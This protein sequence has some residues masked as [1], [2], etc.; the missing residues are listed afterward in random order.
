MIHIRSTL[1]ALLVIG[2]ATVAAAQQPAQQPAQRH[3]K[4]AGQHPGRAARGPGKRVAAGLFRGI[5]LSDA[6]KANIKTVHTKY[7]AQMK[8]LR[9]Q[10][11]PQHQALREARQKGDTAAFK[12]LLQKSADER[13]QAKHI[14]D[15]ERA[16]LRAALTP[17]NQA[18]FD[19]NAAKLQ[20]KMQ[21]K[22]Q[23]RVAK[24][25]AKALKAGRRPG[26]RTPGA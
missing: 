1:G 20:A 14:F 11:K 16:D 26:F 21:A 23:K 25:G 22:M 2:G 12:A 6:E 18:A 7:G 17:A 5:T 3:A 15:A 24:N 4:V 19:A 10:Y 9:E 8:A 13:S